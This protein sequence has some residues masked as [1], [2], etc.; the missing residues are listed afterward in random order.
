MAKQ[1]FYAVCVGRQPGIYTDW[2]EA[3]AQIKGIKGYDN[4]EG[5]KKVS[6]RAEAE[7]Y[8]RAHEIRAV[9]ENYFSGTVLDVETLLPKPAEPEKYTAPAISWDTSAAKPEVREFCAKNGFGFLSDEQLR[10]VEAA[11]GRN[12]LFA[13]PGSGK[14]T[15]LIAR[16]GYMVK[17]L[18]IPAGSIMNM[19][20]TRSA[21]EEMRERFKKKFPDAE[22]PEFRTI[23]SF[24]CSKVLPRLRRAGFHVPFKVVDGAPAEGEKPVT[25]AGILKIVLRKCR[26]PVTDIDQT[27]I[28]A[29][30]TALSGVKNR[31]MT[32]QECKGYS[33]R[34]N[35]TMLYL[36]ELYRVYQAE[37][38]RIKYI[39]YD[40]M[41]IYALNGLKAK[42][43]VLERL[44][45]AYTYWAIDEAQDNSRVQN[46]L[47]ELL[48]GEDG[49]LFMVGDDDQSIYSFRGAEPRLLLDFGKK[50][51][52]RS[53]TMGTNYRSD[54]HIVETSKRFIEMNTRR[55]EKGMRASHA[56]DGAVCVPPSFESEAQMYN[57]LI[58]AAKD[59]DS[60]STAGENALGILF[61]LNISALPLI[62]RL[63]EAGI[64]YR[65]SKPL[66]Q[67]LEDGI[68]GRCVHLIR[69]AYDPCSFRL[70]KSCNFDLDTNLGEPALKQ[71]EE[72]HKSRRKAPVHT[73]LPL[74]NDDHHDYTDRANRIEELVSRLRAA[75][76]SQAALIAINITAPTH[77]PSVPEKLHHSALLSVCDMYEDTE[78]M[79]AA[80]DSVTGLEKSNAPS[81]D[82]EPD[83]EVVS[84]GEPSVSIGTVHYAKGKEWERVIIIDMFD[85]C[86]PG[87]PQ[88]ER[89]G[90][91]DEEPRRVFYVALTRAIN[92]LEIY[93]SK[94]IH[95]NVI[96]TSC[97]VPQF[98]YIAEEICGEEV[99]AQSIHA[100]TAE[101][102]ACVIAQN[103]F[104]GVAIGRITGVFTDYS[105]AKRST[106]GI[107]GAVP[108]RF[109]TYE[110]AWEYAYPGTPVR[111]PDSPLAHE[112]IDKTVNLNGSPRFNNTGDLP[113]PVKAALHIDSLGSLS[114]EQLNALRAA[115]DFYSG[116]DTVDYS[117]REL[118]YAIMYL[119]VN[120]YKVW[121]PL[122]K[123][124][125]ENR[126]KPSC[127]V[128]E[129]GPGPGTSTFSLIEFYRHLALE[130]PERSF[131]LEYTAVEKNSG[132]NRIFN[133]I[134]A[135]MRAELP[136]NLTVSMK[137]INGDAFE[138]VKNDGGEYDIVLESNLVNGYES[139]AA[140]RADGLMNDITRLLSEGGYAI[141]IEPGRKENEALLRSLAGGAGEVK[142]TSVALSDNAACEKIRDCGLRN[143][144]PE[145][146]FTYLMKAKEAAA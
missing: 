127:R 124:L 23:H 27:A 57:A 44:R 69:Y 39:D 126:L 104:Y 83:E 15:V 84:G 99:T 109:D 101:S 40:D 35:G 28:D 100:K 25:R 17:G 145:H 97:F 135:G 71:L 141:L 3:N 32:E 7:A 133:R 50:S 6:S 142:K 29:A 63:H 111:Y 48:A 131:V 139:G 14:T 91:D 138:F 134:L 117:N 16:A 10:A 26:V 31:L 22:A 112:Y 106:D 79:L 98:A 60:D 52:V 46:E 73:L 132:F 105:E 77:Q 116:K 123:L 144:S 122:A 51:G 93:T 43:E 67:L 47:M 88:P 94:K 13:V 75:T 53:L 61:Q 21:A 119:P 72:L 8:I 129:L 9:A 125:S 66:S 30:A 90:Y 36:D 96:E 102:T 136:R 70:F 89:P 128:L 143:G 2:N 65:A 1:V 64:P 140:S 56:Q 95:G 146:W 12:L 110:E 74:L 137:L 11:E 107:S 37:L 41:L 108:K 42:P 68:T 78:K 92:R 4:T 120:F 87:R 114:P 59:A 24:C 38:D 49:N 45:T 55:A 118:E 62:M 86:I 121:L 20:F 80:F 18:G 85:D 58:D 34:L 103:R 82:G 115:A 113:A 54:R 5:Y 19:T 33:V 130:N 81:E 76:P